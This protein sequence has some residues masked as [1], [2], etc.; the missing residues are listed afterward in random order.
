MC[1]KPQ[2]AMLFAIQRTAHGVCLLL[3]QQ[4]WPTK[5]RLIEDEKVMMHKAIEANIIPLETAS[6]L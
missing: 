5:L 6:R 1:P 2:K 3:F 4:S